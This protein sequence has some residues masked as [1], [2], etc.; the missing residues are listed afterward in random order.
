MLQT[1]ASDYQ[2]HSYKYSRQPKLKNLSGELYNDQAEYLVT[3]THKN[4]PIQKVETIQ[5][6]DPGKACLVVNLEGLSI[7]NV[8][9]SF[10]EAR[11]KALDQ[12]FHYPSGS[13]VFLGDMNMSPEEF[14]DYLRL[15]NLSH[16]SIHSTKENTRKGVRSDGKVYTSKL[17]YFV[18]PKNVL[19]RNVTVDSNED[20]SDHAMIHSMVTY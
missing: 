2:C 6:D 1:E 8:H 11:N 17:D 7:M 12:V 13:Y 18:A 15:R 3:L 14:K 4:L 9:L 19:F 20:L 16:L 5:F 10:G